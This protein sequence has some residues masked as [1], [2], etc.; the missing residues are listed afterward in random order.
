MFGLKDEVKIKIDSDKDCVQVIS[1]EMPLAKV[2]EKIE[3]AFESVRGQVKMPGFRPG[4]AP[5]DMVR[6]TYKDAAYER[7]QDV[8]MREG[9]DEAIKSKKIHPV[10]P[11]VI[12]SVNFSPDKPF[13]FAFKVEVAPLIK[14]ADYKGLKLTR[15]IKTITDE[16]VKKALLHIAEINARLVESADTVLESKHFAVVDYEGFMED[17]PIEGGKAQNFL[18]DMSAPQAIM[19]LAEGLL[20]VKVGETKDV[21]VTFPQDS[22]SPELAGKSAVFKVVLHA[23]KEKKISEITDDFA[24]DLGVE[25]L[26]QLKARVRENLEK[27]HKRSA[28][29]E[30][31][32]QIVNALLDGNSFVVP[33]SLIQKQQDYL[34]TRQRERLASQGIAKEDQDKV[35]DGVKVEARRQAEKDVRLAFLLDAVAEA[36]KIQ[37]TEDELTARIQALVEGYPPKDRASVEKAFRGP[38]ADRLRNELRESKVFDWLI[39]NAKMKDVSGGS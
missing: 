38:L 6:N 18:M 17:K 26:E 2:K 19:G 39:R 35:L 3:Q 34:V 36:E 32:D 5:L 12:Q 31:E 4:K 20:G 11:P 13:S 27:D 9:V 23:I 28:Q 8:L 15:K 21:P 29:K 14:P 7:A 22:P 10:Q 37:V 25:S 33:V 16:D 30:I 1:V 24:K